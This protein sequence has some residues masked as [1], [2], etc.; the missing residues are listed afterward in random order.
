[1]AENLRYGR[2]DATAAEL[3]AAAAAAHAH[4]FVAALSGGYAA[5][6]GPRGAWLSGGQ[7]QR[8]ALAR[9]FLR[10]API[11]V[12]DEATASVDSETE[13]LIQDAIERMAGR[14]TMLVIGH[15]LSSLRRA[16]RVIVLEGGR[17]VE[18]GRPEALLRPGRRCRD[19]F[20]AQLERARPQ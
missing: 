4:G 1:V 20:A 10:D 3:E 6:V 12:L 17:V 16:D 19:L 11:L 8:L 9:A 15:R 18:S 5:A 13:E 14:R 2:P 7:R